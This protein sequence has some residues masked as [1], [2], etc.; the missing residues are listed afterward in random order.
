M[1]SHLSSE[2]LD[3]V[4]NGEVS[5]DASQHLGSCVQCAGELA[6]LR[7]V[8][9]NLRE[10]TSAAAEHH[11]RYVSTAAAR[12]VPRMAWGLVA[13]ALFMSVGAP[14]VV[15]HRNASVVAGNVS[16]GPA[17]I[18]DDALLDGVQA[19]LSSSVPD[20]LLPLAGTSTEATNLTQ[21]RK[22]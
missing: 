5:Q 17:A 15:R 14:L 2:Q 12:R 16:Q 18:S 9:G 6:S 13:A 10:A 19:D 3:G 20:S 21:S 11:R 4:L 7:E 1:M 22:N 8:F